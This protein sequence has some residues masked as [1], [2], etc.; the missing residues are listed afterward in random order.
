MQTAGGEDECGC[1]HD[2]GKAE[3]E[4]QKYSPDSNFPEIPQRSGSSKNCSSHNNRSSSNGTP[5]PHTEQMS[6][7][8]SISD[9]SCLPGPAAGSLAVGLSSG[10]EDP[11]RTLYDLPCPQWGKLCWTVTQWR[12]RVNGILFN[13]SAK[14]N[15]NP[16]DRDKKRKIA[17]TICNHAL[18]LPNP[19]MP[20]LKEEPPEIVEKIALLKTIEPSGINAV[21]EDEWVEIEAA[22]DCRA[23]ETVMPEETLNGIIG[24]TESAA[25][26][27]GV[28]YE[29][30][31]GA[32][33]PTWEKGTSW[34]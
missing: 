13:S 7:G 19:E 24:I 16:E 20:M 29:V 9:F 15:E 26:K 5:S 10:G 28:V 34:G 31:D 6:T 4:K 21:A 33:I 17:R 32:Q 11:A 18:R 25:C 14:T 8:I 30:A 2:K 27:R 3:V 12:F 1:G 22:V 23:T